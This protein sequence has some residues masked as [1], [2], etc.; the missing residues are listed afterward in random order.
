MYT[1]YEVYEDSFWALQTHTLHP[2][3][4]DIK[5]LDLFEQFSKPD[6]KLCIDMNTNDEEPRNVKL[7]YKFFLYF[8]S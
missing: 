7:I 1:L 3:V 6:N 2:L 4:M 5:A 8:I